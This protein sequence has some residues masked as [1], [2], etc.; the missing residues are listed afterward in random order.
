MEFG[1]ARIEPGALHLRSRSLVCK[2]EI[3]RAT[4]FLEGVKLQTEILIVGADS[5]VPNDL[6]FS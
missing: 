1:Q 6:S 5:S 3:F 2:D 4:M